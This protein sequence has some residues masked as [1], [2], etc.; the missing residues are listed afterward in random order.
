YYDKGPI[1]GFLLDARVR[2]LTN[3]AK[4]LDDVMRLAYKRYGGARGFTPDPFQ[5]TASEIAGSDLRPFFHTALDTTDELDYREAL[6]WFGLRFAD[7]ETAVSWKLEPRP[8][9]SAVQTDRLRRLTAGPANPARPIART[10]PRAPRRSGVHA[11][12]LR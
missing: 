10:T 4:S 8:D 1:V 2:R 7:S 9:A 11:Q 5:A 6:D 12:P 3:D